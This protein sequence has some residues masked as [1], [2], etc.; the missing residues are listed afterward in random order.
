MEWL[1]RINEYPKLVIELAQWKKDF[2]EAV[3]TATKLKKELDELKEK[4]VN[5]NQARY[6]EEYWN[7]KRQKKLITWRAMDGVTMDVRC[8]FQVD[9]TLPKFTGTNDEIVADVLAWS[10]LNLHYVPDK[11]EFWQYAYETL[12]TRTGDCEDGAILMGCILLNSGIPY[13]RIRLNKGNV[14]FPDGT[15][16]YHCFLTYL[17]ETNNVW[18]MVDWC[19]WPELS[20]DLKL[21]WKDAEFYFEPDS[22]WNSKYAFSGLAK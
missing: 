18:K 10:I 22:S 9:E 12:L 5:D 11:G 4:E 1:N 7:N 8:F 16:G 20:R 2:N 21:D 13:W 14:K 6:L 3:A 17:A 19:Y 15:K